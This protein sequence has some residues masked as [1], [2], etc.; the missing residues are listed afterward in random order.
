VKTCT[1]CSSTNTF[2]WYSGPTCGQCYRREYRVTHAD[3]LKKYNAKYAKKIDSETAH[4][5][6]IKQIHGVTKEQYKTLLLKQ[7]S[8]CAIC[9]VD[10]SALKR[11]LAVDHNHITGQIRGLLCSNCNTAIGS[12]K[13][14][15][16]SLIS[17]LNYLEDYN[18]GL[19]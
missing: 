18:V 2:K 19:R 11:R 8:K 6:K 13:E 16:L 15:S 14:R 9:F 7:D 10:Q 12:L 5:Y 3:Q 17:A 4:G 1:K